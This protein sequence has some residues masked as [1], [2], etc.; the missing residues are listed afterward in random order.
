MIGSIRPIHWHGK[1]EEEGGG[2][3][4]FR[5]DVETE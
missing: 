3:C 2:A 4:L 1:V 5:H